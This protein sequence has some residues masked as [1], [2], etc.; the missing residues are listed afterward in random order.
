M[1]S[2]PMSRI[3]PLS[4]YSIAPLYIQIKIFKLIY[5]YIYTYIK[6]HFATFICQRKLIV[7]TC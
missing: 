2:G 4:K 6:E 5:I 3:C 7:A 1:A